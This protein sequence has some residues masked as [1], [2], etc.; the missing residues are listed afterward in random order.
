MTDVHARFAV[1]DRGRGD[2]TLLFAHGF[3]CDQS[4][5]RYVAPAFEGD[6]RVVLFDFIGAGGSDVAAYDRVR[7]GS[8]SG[9]ADD[10]LAICG[11]LDLED[12][13]LVGHSVSA[14]I[15]VLASLREPDRFRDLVLVGPSPCYLNDPPYTGGF[16]RADIEGLLATMEKNYGG[17]A[18][19]MAPVIMKNPDR[20]ELAG[21]LEERFCAIDPAIARQFAEVTFLS[22]NRADLAGVTVPS[23][24]LQCSDDAIAPQPV[25][26]YLRDHLPRSTFHQLAATG[27]CPHLSHPD[28][29]TDAIRRYLAAPTGPWT[30]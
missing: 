18:E 8:L 19:A 29:T 20:P 10:V 7:Y 26:H 9:Y 3:G 2:T 12:V 16:E 13:V 22:D 17:W 15:G 25:G 28:E 11:A 21:E 23:L 14:M 4:M 5:W 24:V 27:H 30:A 6:H 1:T